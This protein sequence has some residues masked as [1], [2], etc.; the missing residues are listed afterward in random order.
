VKRSEENAYRDRSTRRYWRRPWRR[1]TRGLFGHAPT[2]ATQVE[3]AV[4][5]LLRGIATDYPA[6]V[7]HSRDLAGNPRTHPTHT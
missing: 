3:H 6:L 7:E 5:A 2:T 1:S 4:E